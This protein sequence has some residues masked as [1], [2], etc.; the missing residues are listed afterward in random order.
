[1]HVHHLQTETMT[2]DSG[3][4]GYAIAGEAE[5]FAGPGEIVTFGPGVEHRFWNAGD[6]RARCRGEVYPPHNLEYFLTQVFASIAA[7]GGRPGA[8][9]GAFLMTRYRAEFAMT[10]IPRLGAAASSSRSRPRLGRLFGRYGHFADA[11]APVR[12]PA[13]ATL[14]GRSDQRP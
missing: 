10:A 14:P 1:M 3:R 8:F 4:V 12:R 6:E 13:S 7:H 5:R 9:D 11:P 2:V